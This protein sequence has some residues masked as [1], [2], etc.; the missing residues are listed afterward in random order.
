MIVQFVNAVE[1]GDPEA[2]TSV[3]AQVASRFGV[4]GPQAVAVLCADLLREERA[5]TDRM[6]GFL[7]AANHEAA[8][9][10]QAYLTEKRRVAELRD[11]LNERAAASTAKRERKSA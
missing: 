9:N 1:V 8:V 5:K 2:I 11:I 3:Y 6:R 4:D 10:G 7:A